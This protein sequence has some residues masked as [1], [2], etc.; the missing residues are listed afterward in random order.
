MSL[1]LTL[2]LPQHVLDKLMDRYRAG[3]PE[4]MFMLEEFG[5]LA[6]QPLD[7]QAMGVWE[8]EGRR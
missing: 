8:S 5:V 2:A 4:L 3:D 1:R 7:E 6:I